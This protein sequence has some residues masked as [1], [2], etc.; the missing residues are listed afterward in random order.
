MLLVPKPEKSQQLESV[1]LFQLRRNGED[2]LRHPPSFLG[3]YYFLPS[4]VSYK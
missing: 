1:G 4:L 2:P 3:S